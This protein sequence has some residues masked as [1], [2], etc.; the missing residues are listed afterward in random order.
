[1]ATFAVMQFIFAPIWGGI[2][3]RYGRKPVLI[4]GVMGNALSHLLFGPYTQLWMLLRLDAGRNSFRCNHARS[5]GIY[6]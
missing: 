6:R 1:M 3:D 4:I 2:S 5:Y